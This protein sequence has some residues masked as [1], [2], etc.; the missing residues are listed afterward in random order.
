MTI[1]HGTNKKQYVGDGVYVDHDGFGYIVTTE[2]GY[3][4]TNRIVFEPEIWDS[5]V[6]CIAEIDAILE[7]EIEARQKELL[8]CEHKPEEKE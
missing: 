4:N 7:A 1:P 3:T 2:D 5:L 6:K 8:H